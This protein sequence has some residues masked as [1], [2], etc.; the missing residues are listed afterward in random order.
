LEILGLEECADI[1]FPTH[2]NE[3]RIYLASLDSSDYSQA[4]LFHEK[5]PITGG[6]LS[7]LAPRP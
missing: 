1:T 4:L 5:P 2:L 7:L 6:E 3:M